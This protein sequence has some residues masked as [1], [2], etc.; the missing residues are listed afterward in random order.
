MYFVFDAQFETE[1]FTHELEVNYDTD[2]E[3]LSWER[4]GEVVYFPTGAKKGVL[5]DV[6]DPLVLAD[7]N[8]H[9][10]ELEQWFDSDDFNEILKG[11]KLDAIENACYE[12]WD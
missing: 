11:A 7:I 8:K 12:E 5:L 4:V 1:D 9:M 3:V 10:S 2:S 6:D